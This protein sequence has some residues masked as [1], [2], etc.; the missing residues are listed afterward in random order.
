MV[1]IFDD[2]SGIIINITLN[3]VT[4]VFSVC[5]KNKRG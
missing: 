4:N 5:F 3:T 2:Y 1:K